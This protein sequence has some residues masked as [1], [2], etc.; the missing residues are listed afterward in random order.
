M[1]FLRGR[2]ACVLEAVGHVPENLISVID[3]DESL[4][5]ALV[6]LLRSHGYEA[7]G[8]P[9]AEAF[10]DAGDAPDCIVTDIQMPGISG[11]ELKEELSR[12]GDRTPVIMITARPDPNLE[13]R[14]RASGAVCFLRKP[15]DAGDLV[16]C[17]ESALGAGRA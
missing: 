12:R 4:R 9:T 8:F 16:N 3:D 7:A 10:L 14:A 15:F 5:S 6:G 1:G 13:V 11:I 17:I 2:A